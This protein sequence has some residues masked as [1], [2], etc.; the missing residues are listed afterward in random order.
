M[1]AITLTVETPNLGDL[2]VVD[3]QEGHG[4]TDLSILEARKY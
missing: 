1:E 3:I 2:L 4:L